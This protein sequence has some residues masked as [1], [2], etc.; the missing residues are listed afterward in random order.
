[1][2]AAACSQFAEVLSPTQVR[3]FMD[4]QVRWWFKHGLK[5]PEPQTGKMALGKAVHSA[6]AENF[7]QKLETRE[8][9]PT[10]GVRALFR[11][12]WATECAQTEFRDD[13]N[14]SEL[15]ACG[16]ALVA[17][18]MDEV[19]PAIEPAA[20]EM[21]VVGEIAGIN[22]QG[23][24]DLL[25]VN[26]QIIDLKTSARR[27]TSIEPSHKFQVATYAQLT[28]GASGEVRLD[29]LVKTK[30]P[31]LVTQRYIVGPRDVLATHRLYALAQRS[32]R[33]E[34]YMPNRLSITCSRRNCGYWRCCE[35]EWGGEVPET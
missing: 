12:S 4:C 18:Y 25:D 23:W 14:P 27:P 16:E 6:V 34:L 5:V 17:K 3:C 13:E 22:V 29:T 1:V 32:M 2:T 30:T 33:S 8:D 19:A 26:G 7:A 11:Q 15:A 24:I 35:R 28:P 20:V 10:T 31:A 9:L 21:R